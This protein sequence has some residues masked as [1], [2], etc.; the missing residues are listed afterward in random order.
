LLEVFE[1]FS[2]SVNNFSVLSI[3]E[4]E[5]VAVLLSDL[6]EATIPSMLAQ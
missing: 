1:F 6:W 4:L 5:K 2:F 3:S